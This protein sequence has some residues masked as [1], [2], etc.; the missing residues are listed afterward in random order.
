MRDVLKQW[1]CVRRRATLICACCFMPRVLSAADSSEWSMYIG[2]SHTDNIELSSSN[3]QSDTQPLAGIALIVKDVRERLSTDIDADISYVGNPSRP[4]VNRRTPDSISG[5]ARVSLT[6]SIIPERFFWDIGESFGQTPI[7]FLAADTP[8]NR[9]NTNVLT[10]GPRIVFPFGVRNELKLQG[11]WFTTD[12]GQSRSDGSGYRAGAVFQHRTSH[13][14]SLSLELSASRIEHRQQQGS[15]DFDVRSA[16]IAWN[17]VKG[18]GTFALDLGYTKLMQGLSDQHSPL[19]R[20]TF[21]RKI[22]P[23]SGLSFTLGREFSSAAEAFQSNQTFFGVAGTLAA[24]QVTSDPFRSDYGLVVWAVA[25]D[26]LE[27]SLQAQGRRESYE[28]NS[29]LN[30]KSYGLSVEV[31]RALSSR[32]RIGMLARY[33]RREFA[34][35]ST[36][37]NERRIGVDAS[38]MLSPSLSLTLLVERNSGSALGIQRDHIESRETVRINYSPRSRR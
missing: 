35:L 14:A 22:S 15:D 25:G 20:V 34:V 29:S 26:R 12:F 8:G 7:N 33:E 6:A 16:F 11:G 27:M 21:A 5:T 30:A 4:Y 18:R 19:V 13:D 24:S 28:S 10:T 38:F 31:D 3:N 17:R 37:N 32:L 23:R 1:L 9:Q 36:P 2:A